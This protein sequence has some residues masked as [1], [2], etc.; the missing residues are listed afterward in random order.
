M[1]EYIERDGSKCFERWQNQEEAYQFAMTHPST[2][3]DMEM[4]TGKTRVAIDVSL[5]R[6]DV[7]RVLVVCPKAV[8]SV[9]PKELD[10][11]WDGRKFGTYVKNPKTNCAKTAKEIDEMLSFAC[12]D[13]YMTLYVI[14]NYD[15]VWRGALGDYIIKHHFDMVILDESHR[16]K[17]AGSKVSK[18][19]A[20]LGRR[21]KYKM[22]LSGT[23]MANSPL[24]VYGQYRFLDPSIFGTR[25]NLFLQEYAVM[26]GPE[27]RFIVGFKNQK[28]LNEK[29]NT[30]AYHCKMS[31][32]ADRIK[33]PAKLPP[34]IREVTLP[35]GD[36][37]TIKSL[38]KEFIAEC[39]KG[40]TIVLNNVLTRGL[41]IQ[42]ICSGFCIV[43]DDPMSEGYVK[44]LNTSK[45]EALEDYLLDVPPGERVVVFCNFTHDLEAIRE[46]A[47][48]S[49]RPYM[50][51]SGRHN[52]LEQW[53]QTERAVVG[54]QIQ[55]GAEGVD[56][57]MAR[58]GVYFSLPLDRLDL[59]DQSMAR[60]Y[61]PG[62][63][64]R[65]SFT[66]I[67]ASGTLDEAQ[68][69]SLQKRRSVIDAIKEGSFDFGYLKG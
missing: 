46:A 11:Y 27:K 19:L 15:S 16:A 53:Q 36:Y 64:Q 29:F 26:G 12:E 39:T 40:G 31:E 48:K 65:V 24:D 32:I 8:M 30:L 7:H 13:Y 42:Q 35:A 18:Y 2:M 4:G 43:Q 60:L 17:G 59:Y 51:L 58:Y 33:L 25:H 1:T 69:H 49:G 52:T 44:E 68:F 66:H 34:S 62:Q 14:V 50:E 57:T 67:I 9:W 3:L 56:M 38:T 45:R 20:M 6:E 41:R 47:E 21:V 10:K 37:K 28:T 23:P 5:D 54:V 63:T 61:R 55:A 22:C